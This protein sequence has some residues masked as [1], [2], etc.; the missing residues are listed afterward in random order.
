MNVV[1]EPATTPSGQLI[2]DAHG[3]VVSLIA[4]DLWGD[5][6]EKIAEGALANAGV[7]CLAG[8]QGRKERVETF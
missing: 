3:G 7:M 1:L 5:I 2:A 8:E 4:C 6:L